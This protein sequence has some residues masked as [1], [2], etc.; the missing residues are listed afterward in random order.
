MKKPPKQRGVPQVPIHGKAAHNAAFLVSI[1][2]LIVNWSNNES[3]FL[4]MLQTLIAGGKMSAAIVWHSHRTTNAR[5]ELIS[6]L[7]R[8]QVKDDSLV[9][10]INKAISSFK[11]FSRTRN[12]YC[13][14]TYRYDSD[15][16]LVSATSATSPQDGEPIKFEVKRMDGA[17]INEMADATIRMGHFNQDLWSLV[18]RLEEALGVKRV[19]RPELQKAQKPNQD[20]RPHSGGDESREAPPVPDRE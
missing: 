14:A 13:H 9:T 20:D 2:N 11:G 7:C 6:R 16:H 4:A 3:V 8:E 17:A 5:M 18:W 19:G 15:L 10:E 12:F 1:G